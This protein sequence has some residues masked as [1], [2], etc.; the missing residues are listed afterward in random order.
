MVKFTAGLVK[1]RDVPER[2]TKIHRNYLKNSGRNVCMIFEILKLYFRVKD[3][4]PVA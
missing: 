3:L 4:S 2:R 1:T